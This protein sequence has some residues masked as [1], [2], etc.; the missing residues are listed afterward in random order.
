MSYLSGQPVAPN[1]SMLNGPVSERQVTAMDELCHKLDELGVQLNEIGNRIE[2]MAI[3]SLGPVPQPNAVSTPSSE[4][5]GQL[6]L[7][8][9]KFTSL[10]NNLNW[11]RS[12]LTR[13]EGVL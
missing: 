8:T 11:I 12:E 10:N 1:K 7:V 13:L 3:R 5:V 2:Q 4:P 6:G 9:N